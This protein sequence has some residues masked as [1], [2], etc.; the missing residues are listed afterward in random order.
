MARYTAAY[1]S[2]VSRLEEIHL[3][4][5][6][7]AA[8]ERADPI[9]LRHEINAFCRAAIVLLCAHLEAYVKELGEAALNGM[10]SRSVPRKT[11]VDQFYYH[12]SKDILDGVRGTSEPAKLASKLFHFLHS[13]LSYWSREGPFPNALP[14][15]RFN[16]GFSNPSFDRVQAYFRRFGYLDYKRDLAHLLCANYSATVNMVNHLVD[17]RNKIAHGDLTAAKP[18]AD[19]ADMIVIIRSYSGAT[20]SVFASWCKRNLCAI[21]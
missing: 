14:V 2:F 5:R 7:A 20:D 11:L 8:R 1:S 15:D 19:V 13:D 9:A 10:T 21:R 6:I 3:L 12:I 16:K 17:T 4:R 18:P